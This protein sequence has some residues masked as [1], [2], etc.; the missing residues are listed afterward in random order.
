[1]SDGQGRAAPPGGLSLYPSLGC[2][3]PPADPRKRTIGRPRALT[4]RQVTV[5]L[6]EHARFLA[7][8]AQ[9][10]IV[11]SQRQ[12]ARQCGVSQATISLAVRSKGQYKQRSPDE[13]GID[14]IAVATLRRSRR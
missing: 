1:L 10:Q 13:R 4:D 8:R 9:R 11:K 12:L 2:A 14:G 3:E 5:I 6:E 7:W